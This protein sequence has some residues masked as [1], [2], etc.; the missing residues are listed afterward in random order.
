[1]SSVE[2]TA[3]IPPRASAKWPR[4]P[5]LRL[6]P[7][8]PALGRGRLQRQIRRAFLFGEELCSLSFLSPPTTCTV[9]SA[10]VAA[11]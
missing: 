1:V 7:A 9:P 8:K 6:R 2:M 5:N 4:H 11:I 10:A 3:E